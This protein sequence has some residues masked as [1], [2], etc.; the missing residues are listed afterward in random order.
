[1]TKLI[2]A[3]S[4][5]ARI[6]NAVKEFKAAKAK[7]AEDARLAGDDANREAIPLASGD[8]QDDSAIAVRPIGELERWLR[9]VEARLGHG[10]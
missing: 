6:R 8:G 4:V 7:M 1:M 9:A 3:P 10:S 5:G 2:E